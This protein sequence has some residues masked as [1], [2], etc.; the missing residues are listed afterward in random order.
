MNIASKAAPNSN[1]S[2]HF[3]QSGSLK[4]SHALVLVLAVL[5]IT[6]GVALKFGPSSSDGTSTA[7]APAGTANGGQREV[8][9]GLVELNP[10]QPTPITSYKNGGN[11][12]L[13]AGEE[14]RFQVIG[15]APL[16]PIELRAGGGVQALPGMGGK[17]QVA[18]PANQPLPAAMVAQGSRLSLPGGA[19]PRVSVKV[20]V[21]GA[22][23]PK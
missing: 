7:T 8:D 3:A 20:Q 19:P 9:F 4:L 23:R 22:A 18:G 14:L 11:M 15:D 13:Y 17:V 16:P 6:V 2:G 12:V 10:G 1:D 21:Y 5:A